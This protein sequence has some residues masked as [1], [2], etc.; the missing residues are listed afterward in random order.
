MIWTSNMLISL[1]SVNYTKTTPLTVQLTILM[2][3]RNIVENLQFQCRV[4][5]V[6]AN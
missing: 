6:I 1:K 2:F 4:C 3:A 5:I